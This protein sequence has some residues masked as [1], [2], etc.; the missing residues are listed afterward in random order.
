MSQQIKSHR[1]SRLFQYCLPKRRNPRARRRTAVSSCLLEKLETR[2]LLSAIIVTTVD[3]VVDAADGNVSLRE[4]IDLANAS[5]E[6]DTITFATALY[7]NG[8]AQLLLTNGE[9][10]LTDAVHEITI[11]GPG[12]ELVGIVGQG[13]RLFHVSSDA[14]VVISGLKLSG[15]TAAPGGGILNNGQLTLND[16]WITENTATGG[17]GDD[18]SNGG[19]GT[20]RGGRNGLT[21]QQGEDA[22]GGGIYNTGTLTVSNSLLTDNTAIGGRGGDGGNGGRGGREFLAGY[23]GGDGGT[24]GVGGIGRGGGIFNAVGGEVA[25]TDSTVVDNV[26]SGGNGGLGGDGNEGGGGLT[27]SFP[28]AGGDGG[29]GGNGG[30]GHGGGV[31]SAGTLNVSESLFLG[32]LAKAGPVGSSGFFGSGG[33]GTTDFGRDGDFGV[34]GQTGTATESTLFAESNSGQVNLA[35][36]DPCAQNSFGAEIFVDGCNTQFRVAEISPSANATLPAS[37]LIELTF[38]RDVTIGDGEIQIIRAS[39]G[40]TAQTIDVT[41]SAVTVVDSTASVFISTLTADDYE[42]VV[43]AGAFQDNDGQDSP[44]VDADS[45]WLRPSFQISS[46]TFDVFRTGDELSGD[47]ELMFDIVFSDEVQNVDETDF[48]PSTLGRTIFETLSLSDGGDSD[49]RT[50]AI[51][52]SGVSGGGR[53]GLVLAEDNDLQDDVGNTVDRIPLMGEAYSIPLWFQ[54]GDDFQGT[55]A[56]DNFGDAVAVNADGTVF[57]AGA[58]FN[59]DG[60]SGSGQVRIF[61]RSTGAGNWEQRGNPINGSDAS[62]WSGMAVSINAAGDIVAIG[63]TKSGNNGSSSGETRIFQF[64]PAASDWVLLGN[65]IPGE[66]RSDNSGSHIVLSDD[67]MTIAIGAQ[68]NDGAGDNSGHARVFRYSETTN[69]WQQLGNDIDGEAEGHFAGAVAMSGDG[70]I[71]ALGET[72]TTEEGGTNRGQTRV[73]AWDAASSQWNQLGNTI[74]GQ[75]FGDLSGNS[76]SMSEDGTILA[77]GEIRHGALRDGQVRVFEFLNSTDSWQQLGGNIEGDGEESLFGSSVS[78]SADGGMLAVGAREYDGESG[79]DKGGVWTFALDENENAWGQIGPVIEGPSN[80]DE[81][82][83]SVSL[84]ADGTTLIIGTPDHNG[85]S[86]SNTGLVRVFTDTAFVPALTL[87]VSDTSISESAGSAGLTGTITRDGDLTNALVV[88]LATDDSS[89]LSVPQSVTIEAGTTTSPEFTILAVDDEIVDG[90]QTANV[91]VSAEGFTQQT[92][93]VTVSD[94]DIATLSVE[95]VAVM[96]G[97]EFV[98]TVSVD[99]AVD[100]GFEVTVNFNDGSADGGIDFDNSSGTL[101]FAGTAGET[102]QLIVATTADKIVEF[103]ETFSVSLEADAAQVEDSDTAIAT[104]Q[105]D[106][107]ARITILDGAADEGEVMTFEVRLD[108]AVQ[109]GF[110]AD[111]IYTDVGAVSG[112]DFQPTVNQLTFAGEAGETQEFTVATLDDVVVEGL[113]LFAVDIT[114]NNDSITGGSAGGTVIDGTDTTTLTIDDAKAD[115]GGNLTFSVTLENPVAVGFEVTVS[116]ADETA[117]GGLDF[118]NTS[119]ILNFSGTTGETQQFTVTTT[120]DVETEGTETFLVS[121]ATRFPAIDTSDTGIGTINESE[122]AGKIDI[123]G[124]MNAQALTDGLLAIRYLAGFSGDTLVNG[125]VNPAGSRGSAEDIVSHLAPLRSTMLD[126]DADG[127]SKAL[128]DGVLLLRYLAGFRGASLANNAVNTSGG[129]TAGDDIVEFLASFELNSGSGTQAGAASASTGVSR[130]ASDNWY[131]QDNAVDQFFGS[132]DSDDDAILSRAGGNHGTIIGKAKAGT[133]AGLLVDVYRPAGNA[134]DF[135]NNQFYER[136]DGHRKFVVEFEVGFLFDDLD[137]L[138][139]PKSR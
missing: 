127:E 98:L 10:E 37:R 104:I 92:V 56:N 96:E 126:V 115:E 62:D 130:F 74:K 6:T 50:F 34:R 134:T 78:L 7:N 57:V 117:T 137:A 12:Y 90:S 110:T 9:L 55:A 23:S 58:P 28:G 122:R 75:E 132:L 107:S 102:Q 53:L 20:T 18:G 1:W 5:A 123:D 114:T 29:D 79:F 121:L 120:G 43:P 21:G 128:S 49:P 24:G 64:D 91:I 66:S 116:F 46:V 84:S 40:S 86:G 59:D 16:G 61:E 48:L 133:H 73:F 76:L 41:S 4:A 38:P 17:R 83:T 44:A 100:G 111:V 138:V 26:A 33:A 80:F 136:R 99:I 68:W 30:D 82:G 87:N 8:P 52:V 69:Q 51:T 67:G 65:I 54:S 3:D 11:Q 95:D 139:M 85:A 93:A 113:E 103:D 19:N 63:S 14:E 124:D 106:D 71:L 118:D 22:L 131:A 105:N 81:S 97:G 129:R 101:N 119:Q 13:S 72:E 27:I 109:G 70:S 125:A 25:I 36:D 108:N 77:I 45:T 2:D 112:S 35:G 15:G 94:D 60:G 135:F 89:E 31:W 32:N 39:D 47:S 88:M 42:L